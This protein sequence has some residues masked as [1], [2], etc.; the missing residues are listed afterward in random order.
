MIR[1]AVFLKAAIDMKFD[2]YDALVDDTEQGYESAAKDVIPYSEEEM[3]SMQPSEREQLLEWYAEDYLRFSRDHPTLFRNTLLVGYCSLLEHY[4]VNI[5]AFV[6]KQRNLSVDA[7]DLKG[8]RIDQ[9]KTYLE[10]ICSVKITDIPSWPDILS[11]RII[12]N[13]IVH[14][15]G[16]MKNKAKIADF[17]NSNRT[18]IDLDG[19]DRIILKQ[20]FLAKTSS[21]FRG[22]LEAVLGR[23]L[24]PNTA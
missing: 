3:T 12:R 7:N 9:T 16:A 24:M 18:I 17:L 19:R 10:K 1:A 6:K 21:T 8:G 23:N 20:G 5:C 4:C 13:H 14:E 15:L 2:Q 11:T 22:F